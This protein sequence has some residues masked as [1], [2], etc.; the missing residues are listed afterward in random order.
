MPVNKDPNKLVKPV[1]KGGRPRAFKSVEDIES[2]IQNYKDYLETKNKPP[3][4]A[5]LAFYLGID[6]QTL[7]NYSKKEEYFATI[8]S[9]RD[10]VIMSTEEFAIDRGHSGVIFLMKNYGYKDRQ[11]ISAEVSHV[12]FN[13]AINKLVDKL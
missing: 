3:T 1:N 9:I 13:E 10:W 6:R 11:D 12:N 8:K 5:G 7:Y 4:I 2:K